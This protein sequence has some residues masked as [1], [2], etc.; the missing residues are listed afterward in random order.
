LSVLPKRRGKLLL[1]AW[2]IKPMFRC[3]A[4]RLFKQHASIAEECRRHDETIHLLEHLQR[5][6]E[7]TSAAN[8]AKLQTYIAENV[9]QLKTRITQRETKLGEQYVDKLSRV[10]KVFRLVH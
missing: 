8:H 2:S 10:E 3:F 4:D 7:R 5:E 9:E 1:D 6:Q